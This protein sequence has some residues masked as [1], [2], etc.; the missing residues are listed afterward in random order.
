MY[1]NDTLVWHDGGPSEGIG[2]LIAFLPDHQIGLAVIG[3]GTSFSGFY[4]LQFAMKI[5]D[6]VMEEDPEYRKGRSRKEN[7]TE[8]S[9]LKEV[10]LS[11]EDM[12]ELEGNYAA[13]GSL[14]KVKLKGNRLKASIGGMS[15]ILVP[16]NDMDF[17]VTHWMEKTGLTRIIKPPVDLNKIRVSFRKDDPG[18]PGC[19]ILHMMD[20]SHEICPKYPIHTDLPEHWKSLCGSYQRADRVSGGTWERPGEGRAEIQ[21]QDG[22]LTM[23]GH[24]GPILPVNDT[25]LRVMSGAYHGEHLDRDPESGVILH[26]KWAFVPAGD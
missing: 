16:V 13:F 3:N 9:G 1:K 24:Y 6:I 18:G 5:I 17:R 20:V 21:L 22:I 25:M 7:N 12:L 4:S 26:Q 15:M 19:M 2:S 8:Q 11:Y 10:E 23:S 14:A